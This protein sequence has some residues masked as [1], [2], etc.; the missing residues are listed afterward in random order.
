MIAAYVHNGQNRVA[1]E[2]FQ[3]LWNEPLEPD[4]MTITS[5]LP[6]YAEIAL[7]RE[8]KQI[9][10]YIIKVQLSSNTFIM[11][12][13]VYMYAKCGD[14][15]AGREI[16]DGILFKDVISWN[17]I[18]M[19]YA[20]HGMGSI[21]IE[22]FSEMREKDI[23]PNFSTF[24]S[25]LSACSIAGMMDEGWEYF[26]S[27]RSGY[28]VDPGIEHYGCMLDLLG[29]TGNL[30]QAKCFIDELPLTSTA[31][32]WG[33]LL[34]ASRHHRNIELAELAACHI[35]SLEH[36]NTGCYV[37][38]SN[39]YAEVGRWEDIER[40]KFLMRNQRLEKITGCSI[41]ETNNRTYRFTNHDRS[42]VDSNVIYEVLD[43]ILRKIG[44]ELCSYEVSKTKPPDLARRRANSTKYHS[45]RLAICYGL[46]STSLGNP[47]LVRKNTR[48]CEKCHSAAKKI[49]EFTNREI[50]VGDSKIY[51][52]FRDGH[53][54]CGDYW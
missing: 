12:S 25:L 10:T 23:K 19:A 31:R 21:S 24:V 50:V 26:N 47:I 39:M 14:L 43:I 20:I 4:A 29:R 42:H 38:L 37:L 40:I 16:F 48:I 52:H 18:I 11:N 3:D 36:D 1:L 15:R 34:A 2:V 9:H 17:T 30:D 51:H 33:S 46:I 44:E 49:S 54:S 41:L 28:G 7:L 8:G 22:L 6:A 5:V 13:I 53:C 32:I 45:V 35:S 27:M